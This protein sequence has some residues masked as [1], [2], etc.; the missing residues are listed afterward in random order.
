M[1]DPAIQIIENDDQSRP[2]LLMV[3][4]VSQDSRLFSRQIN[5]FKLLFNLVLTDL[6]GHGNSA[7]L[8]GPYGLQ[9][10]ASSLARAQDKAGIKSSHF[11]GT[12]LGAGAGLLLATQEATRIQSLLLEAPVLPGVPLPSVT[13]TLSNIRNLAM[14]ESMTSARRSW[15]QDSA[16]FEVIRNNPIECRAD[17]HWAIVSE[18]SGKP[19]LDTKL[20]SPISSIEKELSTLCCPVLIVNGEHDL[21]D[22]KDVANRIVAQ[23]PDSQQATIPGG[24]G[25]PLWEFPDQFNHV[26]LNFYH[27]FIP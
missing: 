11:L 12:H 2:W 27:Q 16:W 21:T 7:S 8:D 22:F 13:S 19:W 17:E 4:G 20:A 3:H 25:F 15:F 1:S 26:A 10:F 9:E 18:F 5:A 24:G 6:P 14:N 23:I